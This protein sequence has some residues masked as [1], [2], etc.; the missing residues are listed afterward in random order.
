MLWH[1]ATRRKG[2]YELRLH[3][4]CSLSSL[5]ASRHFAPDY[6]AEYQGSE[7]AK[8][9]IK[10]FGDPPGHPTIHRASILQR[11]L[12]QLICEASGRVRR[13]HC[14]RSDHS[15]SGDLMSCAGSESQRVLRLESASYPPG[16]TRAE[17]GGSLLA[18]LASLLIAADHCR[19]EFT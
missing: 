13:R 14:W 7:P 5:S 6:L 2:I 4:E 18:K 3:C 1:K 12:G 17:G 11:R 15:S 10:G 19:A 8:V 9:E 16:S